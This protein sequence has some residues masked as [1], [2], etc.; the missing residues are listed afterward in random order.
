MTDLAVPTQDV[1]AFR[2]MLLLLKVQFDAGE[3][4]GEFDNADAFALLTRL[5]AEY[6]VA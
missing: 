4:S 2:R 3:I 6:E 1:P 5:C